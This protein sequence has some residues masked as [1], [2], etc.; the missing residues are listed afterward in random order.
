[1][2]NKI[3]ITTNYKIGTS[4]FGMY[5][6]ENYTKACNE[7]NIELEVVDPAKMN[8]FD[9]DTPD[10]PLGAISI[11]GYPYYHHYVFLDML[12][13]LNVCSINRVNDVMI[14]DDKM[15]SYIKL[16]SANIKT[17]KTICFNIGASWLTNDIVKQ[18][19]EKISFPCVAKLTDTGFGWGIVKFNT[20]S[21]LEDHLGLWLHITNQNHTGISP[22]Q[23][24][25]QE[26][27]P[28]ANKNTIRTVYL[29]GETLGAAMTLNDINWK[30]NLRVEGA[31]RTPY[32][33]DNELDTLTKKVCKLFN[34]NF[35]GIDF[36]L[37]N[38]GY[39]V[40][41]LNCASF[42]KGFE[43]ANPHISISKK[44]I[45]YLLN[46]IGLPR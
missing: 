24:I 29:N 26:F 27:I 5:E 30:V 18:V 1:M 22:H 46:E 36:Y 16:K 14:A 25:F 33:L 4:K 23:I 19:E 44:V 28:E 7:N 38:D 42:H 13:K 11:A 37:T 8:L 35:C 6:I 45:S 43:L 20:P 21:D 41:E 12:E 31:Y 39:S 17:P 15:L 10:L 40:A 34:L 9:M 3:I 2:K 32:V